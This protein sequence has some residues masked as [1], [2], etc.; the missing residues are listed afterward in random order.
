M[1]TV[2]RI[3]IDSSVE[4]KTVN[5]M[6]IS[7]LPNQHI[8]MVLCGILNKDADGFQ[9]EWE[10]TDI[11]VI[12]LDADQH[13]K[14]TLFCG[15]IE[16]TYIYVENGVSQI[17]LTAMSS[18]IML[19]KEKKSR[20][21]QD[22]QKTY[23][24][25]IRETV[26]NVSGNV[27]IY[28]N[29]SLQIEKPII[30]YKETDWEFCKRMASHIG[31]PVYCNSAQQDVVLQI[32]IDV[33]KKPVMEIGQ[34]YQASVRANLPGSSMVLSY[35][36]KDYK[37]Y[38]IGDLASTPNG[39]MY[40]CEK[41]ALFENGELQFI[42]RLCYLKDIQVDVMYNSK[43]SGVMLEG[44]V[45]NTDKEN[46]YVKFDIDGCKGEALYPYPWT[47]ITG[48]IMY[49]MPECGTKI[50]VYFRC[51]DEKEA[52]AIVS[53]R[54]QSGYAV[55]A[56]R[57]LESKSGKRIQIYSG[58]LALHAE[59]MQSQNL[60]L[61]LV[62]EEKIKLQSHNRLS[63]YSCGNIKLNAPY[64]TVNTPTELHASYTFLADMEDKMRVSG[65]RNPATGG[66]NVDT[67]FTMGQEFNLLSEQGVLCG[68]E[69]IHYEDCKDDLTEAKSKFSVGK[70]WGSIL[71]GLVV[72]AAVA[73]VAAY[74][75]SVVFTGGAMAA[76]APFI[77]GGIASIV[78]V[79]AVYAKAKSDIDNQENSS[80]W[81]YVGAGLLG[82]TAGAVAG[83]A[84]AMSPYTAQWLTQQALLMTPS[85]LVNPMTVSL[86]SGGS[87]FVTGGIT[88]SNLIFTQYNVVEA[89]SGKNPLKDWMIACDEVNGERNYNFLSSASFIA[90]MGVMFMGAGYMNALQQS[91]PDNVA[92]GALYGE[93]PSSS[94][95]RQRLINSGVQVPNFPNAA[96]HIVAGASAK[97][98]EARAILQHFGI[99]INSAYNGVFLP[100]VRG[101]SNALYHPS[102]HTNAYYEKVNELLRAATSKEEVIEILKYIAE[103]LSN[104]SF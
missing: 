43:I 46:V 94:I 80:V 39:N 76:A 98:A 75:A 3:G 63:M 33:G 19:D 54:R 5:N 27:K 78:G 95:L 16:Q 57:I 99:S 85:A 97:A 51:S 66:G 91:G 49:C 87:M 42:Y 70:L 56:K 72:V 62:D 11:Q 67:V 23:G 10:G 82:A 48:N 102:L 69:H 64:I 24:Q 68:T 92:S 36:V 25:L 89:V 35:E 15:R 53:L 29:D 22:I 6:E 96:H 8:K 55:S 61:E 88:F 12:E 41:K 34:E 18:T 17:I 14:D 84:I 45:I 60:V 93:K 100:T 103:A 101:V 7:I 58:V 26:E 83:F 4:L 90:S 73:L 30:Q 9:A 104:G 21:Y 79:A 13:P 40:I 37:N 81:D 20:S 44:K 32:G 52:C 74:A 28:S 1:I 2:E 86:I 38:R 31:L 77:V 65:S 71:A 59:P 47:P 50:G